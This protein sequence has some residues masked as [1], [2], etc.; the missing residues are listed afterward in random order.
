MGEGLVGVEEAIATGEEVT[1]HHPHQGVL[2]EHL[3]HPAAATQIT[4]IGIFR[5]QLLHPH[6]R[7]ALVDR[8]Q[9]V[10]GGF[11][12]A[13]HPQRIRIAPDQIPQQ[14]AEGGGVLR[15]TLARPLHATA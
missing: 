10:G 4:A 15:L 3:H 12:G 7:A 8:L 11:I 14:G 5:E 2:A 1:L 9:A 6:L 13:E